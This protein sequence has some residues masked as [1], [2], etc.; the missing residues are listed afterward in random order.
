MIKTIE[1]NK[2]SVICCP[3]IIAYN[4]G[5][6]NKEELLNRGNLLS[7]NSYGKYLIKEAEKEKND[8]KNRN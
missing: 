2:D 6:I 8:E 4:N 5:W 3:E 7:K 1:N